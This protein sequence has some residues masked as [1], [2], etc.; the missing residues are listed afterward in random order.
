[1]RRNEIEMKKSAN[2]IDPMVR[3][4]IQDHLM[5]F[6]NN[7]SL[8]FYEFQSSFYAHERKYIHELCRFVFI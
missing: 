4:S 2:Q 3:R 1:M 7:P 5:N 8:T 6:L